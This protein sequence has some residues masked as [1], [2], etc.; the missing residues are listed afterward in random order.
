M[1]SCRF[2]PRTQMNVFDCMIWV[3][4]L[5]LLIATVE[6]QSPQASRR[7]ASQAEEIYIARSVGEPKTLQQGFVLL[8]R[9]GLAMQWPNIDSHF[10]RS[11]LT[12]PMAAC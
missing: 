5:L 9:P 3:V 7:V 11:Q 6:A 1:L 8:T 2:L 10:G 12:P 4:G